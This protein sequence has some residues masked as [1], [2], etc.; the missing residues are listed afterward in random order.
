MA[1][2][3]MNARQKMINMMYLVLTA[4]LAINVAKEVLDAFVVINMGLLQQMESLE[5]KNKSI[6]NDFSN[7]LLVDS[8]NKRLRYLNEQ[9]VYIS[10][11][12]D[13]VADKIEKMKVELLVY[14]DGISETKANEVIMDPIKVD[15][16]DDYDGPTRFFGT[17]DAPGTSGKANDLKKWIEAYR[18]KC[19]N[20]VEK[21]LSDS[22]YNTNRPK[23]RSEIENKLALLLTND[24]KNNK[25]YPTWEMQ[26]F[27]HLP[28]SAALTELTKWENFIRGAEGDM[29]TFL[30]EEISRNAFKFDKIKVAV[31]PKSNFVTSGSNFEADVFLAAYSTNGGNQPTITYGSGINET[32][33]NVEGGVQ[34]EKQNF[35]DGVGKVSFPVS[36][37]GER[38]FAGTYQMK[39]PSGNVKTLPFSTTYHVAPPSATVFPEKMNVLYYGL[40]NPIKISVPGAAP[41]QIVVSASGCSLIGSNGS[42]IAKPTQQNGTAII[43][44]SVKTEDGQIKPMG[45]QEFRIRQVPTPTIKWGRKKQGER[46]PAS[47]A[48]QPIIPIIENFEFDFYSVITSYD[49]YVKQADGTPIFKEDNRGGS[50]PS[51]LHNQM[52]ALKRG[53]TVYFNNIKLTIPGGGSRTTVAS[54]TIM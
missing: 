45:R 23:I 7:Q 48:T 30:W 17:G 12:S 51:T 13:E 43:N 10:Q 33:L 18:N 29:L 20:V 25:E 8:A 36:G 31:I 38:T 40:E 47:E 21:V 32:N 14:V 1:I 22:S 3:K 52:K 49:L 5:S 2:G 53:S 34:L 6:V 42:Y 11:I 28:L 4:M 26:Y 46:V 27:Y 16:K 9:A 35:V 54:F 39:D 15:R 44:V 24:P 19:L 50:I 41:N 37:S